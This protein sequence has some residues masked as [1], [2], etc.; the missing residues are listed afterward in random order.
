[1]RAKQRSFANGNYVYL[2][3][4]A[5]KLGLKRKF[6]KYRVGPSKVT[7]KFSELNYEILGKNDRRQVVHINRLKAAM[8]TALRNR[9]LDR[10]R[11]N[12]H[13]GSLQTVRAKSSSRPLKLEHFHWQ[14]RFPPLLLISQHPY[15]APPITLKQIPF[16]PSNATLRTSQGIHLGQGERCERHVKIRRLLGQGRSPSSGIKRTQARM[17]KMQKNIK[18]FSR[19]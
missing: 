2:H 17:T 4:P 10:L 16:F 8:A 18:F 12:E 11:R 15:R 13:V 9:W 14:L 6:Q 7:A 19:T 3:N 5:W 1:M